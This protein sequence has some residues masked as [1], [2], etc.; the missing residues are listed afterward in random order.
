MKRFW[1]IF[2]IISHFM[3]TSVLASV[4]AAEDMKDGCG[5]CIGYESPHIHIHNYQHVASAHE[6]ESLDGSNQNHEHDHDE[7]GHV[8]LIFQLTKSTQV[9]SARHQQVLN[10]AIPPVYGNMS[11]APPVPPPTA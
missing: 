11:F 4:H 5:S 1:A 10:A 3:V 7:N 2:T 9:H 6:A 8:H